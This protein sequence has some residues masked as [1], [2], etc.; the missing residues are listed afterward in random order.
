MKS[1]VLSISFLFFSLLTVAST[2]VPKTFVFL[3]D[4]QHLKSSGIQVKAIS[5][6]LAPFFSVKAY[7]GNSDLALVLE[8]P[9]DALDAKSLG[10]YWIGLPDGKKVQLQE[11]AFKIV[12]LSEVQAAHQQVMQA[13]E[14]QLSL[15]KKAA[16]LTKASSSL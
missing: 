3:F 9:T 1:W 5:A 8:L 13:Y 11:L 7:G 15:K 14:E 12:N 16:K 10:A 2:P 4:A 6:Q